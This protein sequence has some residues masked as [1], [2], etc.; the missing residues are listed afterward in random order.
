[1]RK[2][3]LVILGLLSIIFLAFLVRCLHL[4][5]DHYYITLLLMLAVFVFYLSKDW[6]FRIGKLDVGWVI[7]GLSVWG[8][9]QLLMWEWSWVGGWL[10]LAILVSFITAEFIKECFIQTGNIL[11]LINSLY[12]FDQGFYILK[13]IQVKLNWRALVLFIILFLLGN[14]IQGNPLQPFGH[15][16]G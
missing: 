10:L 7:A 13:N 4:H 5:S 1:M 15:G 8:I 3:P 2:K 11:R 16:L 9:G 14:V 6:H 12:F